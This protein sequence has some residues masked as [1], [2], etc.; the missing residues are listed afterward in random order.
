VILSPTISARPP[1]DPI[2]DWAALVDEGRAMLGAMSDGRWTDFNVHDPGI[3]ILELLAYAL[4]DLGYR[5][6]HPMADLLAGAAPLLGPAE[7]LTTRAVTLDDMRRLGLDVAGVRNLW[8]EPG[9]APGLKLRHTPGAGDLSFES[10]APGNAEPVTLTGV[11]RVLIEKSSRQDF[12]SA[13]VA[14]AVARRL[15]AERNL[16]EDFEAFVVL[17][18]QP[19]IVAADLEI[20]DLSRA[21]AILLDLFGRLD[22]Y[23]SPEALR[24]SV[25]VLRGQGVSSD[26]IYDGPVL[27][28]GVTAQSADPNARRRMLHLS[29]VVSALAA[30]P[31]VRATRRVR[32]G[33][34]L[35][36]TDAPT[37]AWSLAVGENRTP[38]LDLRASRLRLLI[39]GAVALDSS[40]R[41]DLVQLYADGLRAQAQTA[42]SAMTDTPVPSGRDRRLAEYRPLRFD[43]PGT[44]GVRPGTLSREADPARQSAA[45]Q[46]RAYLM[47]LDA[48]LAGCFAQ[49]A[50]VGSL[51]S[52]SGDGRSYYAQ[53][54]ETAAGEAA[55]LPDVFNADVLQALV[56]PV[57]SVSAADRR[58]RF[59][60]HLLARIGEAAPAVPRPPGQDPA[61]DAASV[62]RQLGAIRAEF[63]KSFPRLSAGRGSGADLLVDADEPP[64]IDRIRLKL[65]LPPEASKRMR[66][67]EHILLRG[68]ADDQ[69][70]S[71][72]LLAAAARNDPYSLQVS[73]VL[74][75]SL[76][77]IDGDEDSI[78]RVIRDE[79]PAHLIAYVRWLKPEDF[80]AFAEAHGQWLTALRHFRRE[81]LGIVDVTP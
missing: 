21:E 59:L 30:A 54:P 62:A 68:F 9:Q 39:S 38:S 60:G 42:A 1:D 24:S 10:D 36:E 40:Q 12:A 13:D 72:P 45:N 61:A 8:I 34:S 63:L 17:D 49:L 4:T 22:A 50:G 44:Y 20:D 16:G 79:C 7:S 18:P 71:Q 66:L 25:T 73:F 29:D 64:L 58:N 70:A 77:S 76:K 31:G 52:V 78:A 15:H 47:M 41:P 5:A 35:A 80:D 33:G 55:L 74:D 2:L 48:L 51:L 23:V 56:E 69:G 53:M 6:R 26:I 43:M 46:L 67:I 75:Q 19:V 37:L 28:R 14:R 11:H 32:I 65:G 57:G 81:Q 27:T 3:T